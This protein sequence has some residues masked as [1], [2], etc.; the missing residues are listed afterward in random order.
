MSDIRNG[1]SLPV[2]PADLP[3]VFA[4]AFNTQDI[5][6]LDALFEPEA[7]HVVRPGQ[8]SSGARRRALLP[9]VVRDRIPITVLLRQVYAVGDT[10]LL[11]N[12]YVHDG[13]GPDGAH[14]H[15]EGTA[16]DIARRGADGYWRYLI[17]NPSGTT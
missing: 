10:A 17:S 15:T 3:Y 1:D 8:T 16:T 14:V 5:E 9:T 4:N 12:D 13:V 7:M 6:L 11:I 2:D